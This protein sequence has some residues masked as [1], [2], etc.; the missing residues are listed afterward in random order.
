MEYE[1]IKTLFSPL[2]SN[3]FHQIP[4]LTVWINL[5]KDVDSEKFL[6]SLFESVMP[7]VWGSHAVLVTHFILQQTSIEHGIRLM[8]HFRVNQRLWSFHL[9]LK[10]NKNFVCLFLVAL[11]NVYYLSC[12]ESR[13]SAWLSRSF[14][15]GSLTRSQSSELES[16][17]CQGSMKKVLLL[18]L[19]TWLLEDQVPQGLSSWNMYNS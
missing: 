12:C 16:Q 14:G 1:K 3:V 11:N 6:L 8:V 10:K 5:C 7:L 9:S 18:S 4:Y 19:L 2:N 17:S 15:L 13:F